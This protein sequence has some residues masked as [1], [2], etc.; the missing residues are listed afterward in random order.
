MQAKSPEKAKVVKVV[1][2]ENNGSSELVKLHCT[3]VEE[4][5]DGSQPPPVYW[6]LFQKTKYVWDA[7]KKQFRSVEFPIHNTYEQYFESKGHQE[8]ADVLLAEKTYGNN[9]MEMVV[10]EFF[11]LFI[12]RATAP[13]F[14]FQIFSVLLWCL[15]EYMYYSLFTLGM[16][17]SFECILVQ[18][19]LRNMSEIRKMGN[20]PYMINVFRNRKWRPIKSNLLVPGDL[21]SITRSQDE[22]LVPCDLLLI[23][24]TCI[25]DESML[26]GRFDDW[27]WSFECA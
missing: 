25:V 24:G 23:R 6:F 10:P 3:K 16:L 11:E 22:N 21:V 15:D 13:F 9:N 7:D 1:P 26:T 27:S 14:V 17:I 4:E 18:Q 5:S 20:R 2:T 12:E 19:Q 8:D